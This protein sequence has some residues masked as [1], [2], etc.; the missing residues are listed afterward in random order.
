[1]LYGFGHHPDAITGPGLVY[2]VYPKALASMPFPQLWSVL[3]FFMLLCLGLDSQVRAADTPNMC[4][5]FF[6]E[7]YPIDDSRLA[8]N[9]KSI[10]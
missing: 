2:V 4:T 10:V 7:L 8:V 5:M 1:M 9:L 6:T 3:F